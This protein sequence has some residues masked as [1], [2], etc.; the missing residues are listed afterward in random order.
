MEELLRDD[1]YPSGGVE[2][3]GLEASCLLGKSQGP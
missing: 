1:I 2:G 3:E